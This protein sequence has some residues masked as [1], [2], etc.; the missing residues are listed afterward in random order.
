[1]GRSLRAEVPPIVL[2]LASLMA[3]LPPLAMAAFAPAIY[4]A[5]VLLVIACPCAL[6]MST[7]VSIVSPRSA[8]AAQR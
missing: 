2:V 4:R 5:L 8:A 1:M 7:P 6:V 3:V